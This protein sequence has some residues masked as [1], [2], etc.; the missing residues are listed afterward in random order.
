MPG[1]ARGL[2]KA[3]LAIGLGLVLIGPTVQGADAILPAPGKTASGHE[4][5]SAKTAA[6]QVKAK[7]KTTSKHKSKSKATAKHKRRPSAASQFQVGADL[8]P[9]VYTAP[10]VTRPARTRAH[11]AGNKRKSP[12]KT[13]TKTGTKTHPGK[14]PKRPIRKPPTRSRMNPVVHQR[15]HP[16][17]A[18]TWSLFGGEFKFSRTGVGT[19][20]DTVIAQRIGVFCPTVNDQDGQLVLRLVDK[21]DYVGTWQWFNPKTCQSA[22][23]GMV[24]I[25]VWRDKLTA[26][27]TAYP[28]SGQAG[29]PDTTMMDRLP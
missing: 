24:K 21:L 19:I 15:R 4:T 1:V 5:V 18:G 14:P 2:G 16:S 9:G 11:P 7:A 23:Y 28:P 25:M 6:P 3:G 26:T 17:L 22:G 29:P 13:G 10:I 8:R 27:F 20:S 12:G